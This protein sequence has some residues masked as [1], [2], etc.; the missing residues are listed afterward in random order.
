MPAYP[1]RDIDPSD[2]GA[3]LRDFYTTANG[4][5]ATPSATQGNAQLVQAAIVRITT[6]A[7]AS[8]VRIPPAVPGADLTIINRGANACLV[9]PSTGDAINGGAA[10]ASFSLPTVRSCRFM[11]AVAGQ[12]DV[13][14]SA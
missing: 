12:W 5:T 14:L 9:F 7:A 6:A 10:N 13:Q 8:G 3:A 2:F 11:C 4:L 1:R